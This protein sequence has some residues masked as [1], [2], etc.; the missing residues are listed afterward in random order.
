MTISWLKSNHYKRGLTRQMQKRRNGGKNIMTVLKNRISNL[1][2][3]VRRFALRWCDQLKLLE[4]W[5]FV[6]GGMMLSASGSYWFLKSD[7]TKHLAD[8]RAQ[9]AEQIAVIREDADKRVRQMQEIINKGS[10]DGY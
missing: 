3:K 2:R 8:L 5:L 1:S 7:F 6:V 10:W 4:F 9:S